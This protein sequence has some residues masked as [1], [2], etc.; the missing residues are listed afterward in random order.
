ME[1]IRNGVVLMEDVEEDGQLQPKGWQVFFFRVD[2]LDDTR[3]ALT[4]AEFEEMATRQPGVYVMPFHVEG[5]KAF[6]QKPFYHLPDKT[7]DET[8]IALLETGFQL[9]F[10]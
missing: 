4:D 9:E 2:T 5:R 10:P 8:R 7:Y 3:E 6:H 1:E